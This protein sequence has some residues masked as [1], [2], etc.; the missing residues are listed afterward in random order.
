MTEIETIAPEAQEVVSQAIE[1]AAP[2]SL[3][4]SL[5]PGLN[6]A[7]QV[8]Y[9][10]EVAAAL[11]DVIE[12]RRLY[13]QIGNKRHVLYEGWTLLGTMLGVFPIVEWTRPVEG[14]WEARVVARTLAGSAVSAAEA[15][16]TR[17]ERRWRDADEYAIRSMAQ[18]RAGSKALRMP[19]GFVV[20][21]AGYE[22]TPAEEMPVE[23]LRS[24]LRGKT[25]SARPRSWRELKER[26]NAYGEPVNSDFFGF[27][28]SARRYLFPGS[29]STQ[30]LDQRERAELFD[31]V[32]RAYQAL[33]AE[34]APGAYPPPD[35]EAIRQ[36]FA[37][38][39]DGVELSLPDEEVVETTTEQ[40]I[41]AEEKSE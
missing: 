34:Y 41:P 30:T 12:R 25:R 32:T 38:A 40:E 39:F 31:V 14:G 3:P 26:I 17:G 9:A 6:P 4:I 11:A 35:I 15:M 23:E 33:S 36:A 37:V 13:I 7:A 10:R 16:C 19:L 2:M 29:V 21:L 18:T 8:E 22:P 28:D 20:Q 1:H 5:L 27:A 24:P